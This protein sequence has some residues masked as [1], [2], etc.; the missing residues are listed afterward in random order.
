MFQHMISKKALEKLDQIRVFIF[1]RPEAAASLFILTAWFALAEIVYRAEAGIEGSNISSRLEAIWWGIVTL[2]TV[3][4]GDRYPVTPTGRVFGGLLMISGVL[5]IA[6]L[7]A[8]VSSYFLEK[9]LRERR[10]L[11]DASD[12]KGHFIICGWKDEMAGFL[13]QILESNR[14]MKTSQIVLLNNAPDTEIET[15]LSQP[16]LK[17]VKYVKGDF[18]Q[19]LNLRRVSPS[20]AMKILILADSTPNQAGVLPTPTEA[21]ARTVMTAMTLNNISKGVLVAAEI[22][23]SSMDQYLRLA[24]VNE[25][26]YSREYSRLLLAKTSFGTGVS[27]IFHELLDPKGSC[28]LT[29]L[30]VPET[31]LGKSYRDLG[32]FVKEKHPRSLL[33]GVLEN[34]GNS[35]VAKEKALKRAQQTPNV[36]ELVKNLQSVK[37]LKF[38]LPMFGPSPEYQLKEGA[39][40]IVI[41]NHPQ[42]TNATG[43]NEGAHA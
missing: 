37:A 15:L 9:A 23:D 32:A 40:A 20:T 19:E 39:M 28:F 36:S 31:L 30:P 4:Y 13:R 42:K 41:E 22:L 17:G 2:L 12:L 10:G 25:I 14:S 27:N 18:F 43:A 35:F 21:D 38:N 29:T 7:T 34:S 3:G 24:H 6:I 33:I 1:R 11:V 5:G 16:D 8:K 26:I